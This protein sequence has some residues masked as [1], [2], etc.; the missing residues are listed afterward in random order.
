MLIFQKHL[1][2]QRGDYMRGNEKCD[3]DM[4]DA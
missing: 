2:Y 4:S 1:K 3:V